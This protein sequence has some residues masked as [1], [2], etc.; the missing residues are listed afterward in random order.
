MIYSKIF[1][2]C[3]RYIIIQ[4]RFLRD[5]SFTL[6]FSFFVIII[7]LFFRLRERIVN[8][9]KVLRSFFNREISFL[10]VFF[11]FFFEIK[12]IRFIMIFLITFKTLDVYEIIVFR[13]IFLILFIITIFFRVDD[14]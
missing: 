6:L 1:I 9:L 2:I 11:L 10:F 8:L 14:I 7:T 5:M 13:T 3:L 4:T 12:T